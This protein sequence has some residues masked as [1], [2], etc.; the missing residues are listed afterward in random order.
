MTT[1]NIQ[2]LQSWDTQLYAD[3]VEFCPFEPYFSTAICGN[4]QLCE[5]E[6]ARIG[7]LSL[8]SINPEHI[9]L[10]PI[11][12]IDSPG[13][14]DIKW[15]RQKSYGQIIL[16]MANAIGQIVFY[17]FDLDARISQDHVQSIGEDGRLALSCDWFEGYKLTVSDSNGEISCLSIS[18]NGSELVSTWKAHEYEA[19]VASFDRH[20]DQLI[21]SGG[22]DSSFRLW[23]LRD[24]AKPVL[25]NRKAHQMGVTSI[26]TSPIDCNVLATGRYRMMNKV[27]L[28]HS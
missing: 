25:V 26:E 22:D 17:R 14:L 11:Q 3:C 19:W 10:T 27:Y 18:T 8:H 5:S 15:C 6:S 23:D 1:E 4:Y 9:D 13:V 20:S 16:A 12:L 28:I 2:K 7:R 24:L 21:Y